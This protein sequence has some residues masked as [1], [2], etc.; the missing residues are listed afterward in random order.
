LPD[1]DLRE[2]DLRD[3][4]LSDN[5]VDI[6]VCG[7]A[8]EHLPD[9]K[10]V[11]A[12]FARVLRPGGHLVISDPHYVLSYI[13]PTLARVGADGRP[14]VLAEHHHTLSAYLSAALP[15]GFQVRHCEEIGGGTDI[16]ATPPP[17]PGPLPTH[18]SWEIQLRCWRAASYAMHVPS[19]VIWH[20]QLAC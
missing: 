7:L 15:L 19:V 20:F 10:P 11:L 13:R 5:A 1:A 14:A 8:L 16:P 12:E 17:K 4:P 2:A 9:L 18:V 6:I 3:I